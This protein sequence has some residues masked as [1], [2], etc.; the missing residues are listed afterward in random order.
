ML[1]FLKKF[2]FIIGKEH[3][4]TSIFVVTLMLLGTLVEVV[5]LGLVIPLVSSL[6]D[7]NYLNN[8]YFLNYFKSENNWLKYLFY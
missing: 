4:L 8:I 1:S 3:T 2:I 6:N 5:S 7:Y